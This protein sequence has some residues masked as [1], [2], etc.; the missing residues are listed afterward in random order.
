M[1]PEGDKTLQFLQQ[2]KD[3]DEQAVNGLMDRHRQAVRRL[4]QMRLDNAI[5]RR[6]AASDVV[7]DVVF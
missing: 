7:Q 6:V 4:I 1:W 2:I 5:A 3:G